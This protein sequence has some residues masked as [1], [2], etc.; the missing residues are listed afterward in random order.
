MAG[1]HCGRQL[2]GDFEC[3]H[4]RPEP[5]LVEQLEL[6]WGAAVGT[7]A[8]ALALEPGDVVAQ[9]LDLAFMFLD[10]LLV[11][12]SPTLGFGQAVLQPEHFG[13]PCD[14]VC[15]ALGQGALHRPYFT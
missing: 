13:V 6:V 8:A 14:G 11:L 10:G 5:A 3:R 12:G 7:G 4:K 9:R 15:R 1:R 2:C